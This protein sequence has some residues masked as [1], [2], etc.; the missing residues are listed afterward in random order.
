M[1]A[2]K[3]NLVDQAYE[4]NIEYRTHI[5]NL[6]WETGFKKNGEQSGTD[7]RS[8]R[9]E[10]IEIRLT[11]ELANHY[12]VYYRT[13]VQNFGWLGLAR[14]GEKSGSQSYSYRME[15]IEI[16]LVEKGTVMSEY[17]KAKAFYKK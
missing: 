13:H 11:G 2:I 1:E 3:I 10:A 5:Q 7:H 15:A 9:L 8:L 14:N 6:G 12:D 4:G 17:G 16:I